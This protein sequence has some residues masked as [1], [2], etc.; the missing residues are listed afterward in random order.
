MMQSLLADR[1]KWAIHFET[2]QVPVLALT[3]IKSGKCAQ[4]PS[5]ASH[6]DGPPCDPMPPLAHGSSANST[7]VLGPFV[8]YKAQLTL[9]H[10]VAWLGGAHFIKGLACADL[11]VY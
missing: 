1:F 5:H 9:G 6:A 11:Q 4:A 2:Q 7:D 10:M 8:A 3:L